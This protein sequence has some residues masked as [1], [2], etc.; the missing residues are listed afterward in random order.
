MC[1]LDWRKYEKELIVSQSLNLVG[2]W[3]ID[4]IEKYQLHRKA[5]ILNLFYI[6]FSIENNKHGIKD[7]QAN[8]KVLKE[9]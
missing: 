3:K 5:K 4:G 1:L 8:A 9:Y 7:D 2:K 6:N